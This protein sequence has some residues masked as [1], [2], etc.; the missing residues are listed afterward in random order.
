MQNHLPTYVERG[1]KEKQEVK[2]SNAFL[3]DVK[4]VVSEDKADYIR[5]IIVIVIFSIYIKATRY[6]IQQEFPVY[7]YPHMLHCEK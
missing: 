2:N 3:R 6:D 1:K 4:T 7:L 5:M